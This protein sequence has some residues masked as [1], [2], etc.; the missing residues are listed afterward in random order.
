MPKNLE[1]ACGET[2]KLLVN[3]IHSNSFRFKK[4]GTPFKKCYEVDTEF[5]NEELFC[6]SCGNIYV[7]ERDEYFRYSKGELTR[8][9]F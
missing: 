7:A 9:G 2:L 8:E 5:N 3:E 4:D 6:D 1:C